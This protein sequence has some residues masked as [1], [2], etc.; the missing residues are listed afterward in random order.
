MKRAYRLI[1]AA[2]IWLAL[3]V[4]YWTLLQAAPVGPLRMLVVFLSFFTVLSNLLAA[5]ALTLPAIAPAS[6]AGRLLDQPELRAAIMV[7]IV[8]VG[9]IFHLALLPYLSSEP[10]QRSAEIALHYVAPVAFVIDWLAFTPHGR[11]RW[12]HAVEWLAYPILYAVWTLGHGWVTGYWPYPFV[13]GARLGTAG[14]LANMGVLTLVF[15]GLGLIVV[16]ADRALGRIF[17]GNGTGDTR[18]SPA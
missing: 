6:P 3:A 10:A 5:L 16:L 4:N 15:L 18:R 2:A 11:L 13:D 9:V 8:I 12:R 7:Y 1:F 17:R 14:V